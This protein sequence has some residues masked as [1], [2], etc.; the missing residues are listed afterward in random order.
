MPNVYSFEG[1]LFDLD[2]VLIDTTELH[3]RVWEEFA[4]SRG[5]ACTRQMLLAT[6]GRKASETIKIWLNSKSISDEEVAAINDDLNVRVNKRLATDDVPAVPGATE[7]VR[8]LAAKQVPMAVATSAVPANAALSLVRIGLQGLFGAI[9]TAADVTQGK[10]HPEPY[11]KAAQALG[12]NPARC[13]VV[14][15]S[16][17]GIQAAKAAGAKCLALATTFPAETL[18]MELPEWL[19]PDLRSVPAELWPL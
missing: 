16:V 1:V 4:R 15:D 2:G 19:V 14:E 11:L 10:P 13:V 5:I 6:N 8:A 7:L 18:R 9:V 3:Y 17:A 12:V